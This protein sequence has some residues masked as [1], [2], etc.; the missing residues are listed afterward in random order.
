MIPTTYDTV[1]I[2]SIVGSRLIAA[3]ASQGLASGSPLPDWAEASPAH[4]SADAGA[5]PL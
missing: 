5:A 2:P 4:S 1:M 3:A